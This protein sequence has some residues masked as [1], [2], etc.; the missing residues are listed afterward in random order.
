MIRRYMHGQP[1]AFNTGDWMWLYSPVIGRGGSHELNCPW[2][3][4]YTVMKKISDVTKLVTEF[5]TY[6][7][8]KR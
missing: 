6:T 3:E 7:E 8:T 4:S 1:Y 5:K 2:K